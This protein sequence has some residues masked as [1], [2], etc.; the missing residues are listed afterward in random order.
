MKK[1]FYGLCLV[2][3]TWLV[4]FLLAAVA[5]SIVMLVSLIDPTL[6][7]VLNVVVGFAVPIAVAVW[8]VNDA[9]YFKEQGI[10]TSPAAWGWGVFL[11]IIVFL[12]LYIIR[13][14]ITWPCRLSYPGW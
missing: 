3:A 12:P 5:V 9:Q 7:S 8:V 4:L 6:G 10:D 1:F 14:K 13:R 11:L 2:I